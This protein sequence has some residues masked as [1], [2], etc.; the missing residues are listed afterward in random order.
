[1]PVRRTEVT[2]SE[3]RDLEARAARDRLADLLGIPPGE[4]R[5]IS[6]E[7]AEAMTSAILSARQEDD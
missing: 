3:R 1:M 4:L 5:I 7:Q 2:A 6:R